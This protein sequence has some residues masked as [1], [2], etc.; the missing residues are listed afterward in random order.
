MR[1]DQP[2]GLRAVHLL[3]GEVLPGPQTGQVDRPQVDL[4]P[5]LGQTLGQVV[6]DGHLT[7]RAADARDGDQLAQGGDQRGVVRHRRSSL[8]AVRPL[9]WAV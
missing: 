7:W 2:P 4:Q 9:V 5:E 6:L 8:D 3:T 1:S